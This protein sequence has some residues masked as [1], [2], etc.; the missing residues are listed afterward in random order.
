MSGAV[1]KWS[2]PTAPHFLAILIAADAARLLFIALSFLSLSGHPALAAELA[3][4]ATTRRADCLYY[5]GAYS[6]ALAAYSDAI[7]RDGA[8]ADYATYRRAVL[9][10]LSGDHRRKIEELSLLE[11]RWPNSRWLSKAM[12]EKALAY[13]ETG[14]SDEAAESYRR[15]LEASQQVSTDELIRM[16]ETM[17]KLARP[18]RRNITH[19]CRRGARRR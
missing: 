14:K 1:G 11:K 3:A 2:F 15:R 17:H 19:P 12:L 8:D 10:G 6:E 7:A 18:A 4:D 9:Y 13:E 5:V 16:A